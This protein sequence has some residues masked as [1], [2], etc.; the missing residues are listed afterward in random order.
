MWF[1]ILALP[2]QFK[3][4]ELQFYQCKSSCMKTLSSIHS[5][6]LVKESRHGLSRQASRVTSSGSIPRCFQVSQETRSQVFRL[7]IL[8]GLAMPSLAWQCLR[9]SSEHCA[10]I[11]VCR[12]LTDI[13]ICVFF[14]CCNFV[15]FWKNFVMLIPSSK[16]LLKSL[17]SSIS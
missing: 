8:F 2:K 4:P 3:I 6:P 9:T 13:S 1:T 17:L 14:L 15:K 11:W 10:D 12:A 7:D 5:P 16:I